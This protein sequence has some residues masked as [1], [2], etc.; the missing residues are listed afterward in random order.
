MIYVYCN[1]DVNKD[2]MFRKRLLQIPVP[3]KRGHLQCR[4]CCL[5]GQVSLLYCRVLYVLSIIVML[6]Y[7]QGTAFLINKVH[8]P[9][10]ILQ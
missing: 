6:H 3:L 4:D 5:D 10:F 9:V 8:I 1:V 7:Q 2:C